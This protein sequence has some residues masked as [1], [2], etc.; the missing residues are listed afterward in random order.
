MNDDIGRSFDDSYLLRTGWKLAHVFDYFDQNDICLFQKLRYE[1]P[2]PDGGKPEKRFTYRHRTN[3]SWLLY[4]GTERRPLYRLQDIITSDPGATIYAME[5]EK[6][7]DQLAAH[8]LVATVVPTGWRG[9]DVEPLRGRRVCYLIDND[10]DG[11]GEK[12]GQE[13]AKA[14]TGIVASLKLA[15]SNGPADG[16]NIADAIGEGF[17]VDDFVEACDTAPE[18]KPELSAKQNGEVTL[19]WECMA[20]VEPE[21]VDWL[22]PGRIAR[23]KLTLICGDPGLGKSQISLDVV[24]HV[25]NVGRFPDGSKAP[26]GSALILT[27][28]DSAK[29]T[30]RPRLEAVGADLTRVHRLKAAIVKD[31][32]KTGATTFSLQHDLVALAEKVRA[33]GDAAIV[34]ID[35]IT[36]YMGSKID[37]HRVTD[38][39]RRVGAPR[40]MGR[41]E[42]CRCTWHHTPAE[43]RASESDP[44]HRRQHRLCRCRSPRVSCR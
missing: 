36:S 3:G 29:D 5:S 18:H 38:C 23:G 26:S 2:D 15:R 44:R 43:E 13:A 19:A 32:N 11:K 16:S 20:D 6:V 12:N 34:I 17:S 22:W 21:P 39:A 1:R 7:A 41:G 24:A 27:A 40:R 33:V 28:E 10:A 42:P 14:L 31:G 25:T 8:G 4:T 37:S 30:V 35:P 9:A